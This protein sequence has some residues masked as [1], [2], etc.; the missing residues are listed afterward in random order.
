MGLDLPKELNLSNQLSSNSSQALSISSGAKSGVGTA[1]AK[2][3]S[4]IPWA[5]GGAVALVLGVLLFRKS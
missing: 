1:P 3:S 5:I 4:W 2:S